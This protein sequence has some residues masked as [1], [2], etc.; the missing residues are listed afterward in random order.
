MRTNALPAEERYLRWHQK[1]GHQS[2]ATMRCLAKKGYLPKFILQIKEEPICLG[3]KLGKAT[4]VHRKSGQIISDTV[5][6]PG[7]LIH[8]D[9]AECRRGSI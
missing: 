1:M 3:C 5:T 8:A 6:L 9:Q 2:F 7:D 4:K